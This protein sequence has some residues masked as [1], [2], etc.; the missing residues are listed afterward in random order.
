[1]L[2]SSFGIA[3]GFPVLI[4][5][6]MAPKSDTLLYIVLGICVVYLALL[7]LFILRAGRK[8]A[9]AAEKK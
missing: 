4:L 6:G 3:F 5:V 8:K 9:A 1:M 7:L 2:G